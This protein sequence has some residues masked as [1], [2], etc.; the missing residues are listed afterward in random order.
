M[1]LGVTN[2]KGLYTSMLILEIRKFVW[3]IYELCLALICIDMTLYCIVFDIVK[4][5]SNILRPKIDVPHVSDM[6]PL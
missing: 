2:V 6:V 1:Q 3:P 5:V 4:L